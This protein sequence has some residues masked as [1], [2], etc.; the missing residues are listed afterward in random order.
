MLETLPLAELLRQYRAEARLSQEELA[1]RARVSPRTIGD[2]E[3]GVSLRPRAITISL[4]AQ[5]LELGSERREALHAASRRRKAA[6]VSGAALPQGV[7]LVGRDDEISRIRGLLLDSATRLVTLTGG[8]G[9]GKT[10]LA[11]AVA[12]HLAGEFGDR[13]F[14][15]EFAALPDAALVPTKIALALGVR[16]VR[17]ESV[18]ASL[19]AAI[20]ERPTLLVFDNFE[21]VAAAASMVA[22]LLAATSSL[23]VLVTS[24][25]P[26]HLSAER[27]VKVG[28]LSPDSSVRLLL[29]RVRANAPESE[30]SQDDPALE[31]LAQALGGLPLAIELAAPLLRT[32]SPAELIAR[33]E[34]PLDVLGA[35]RDSIAWSY[36]L[37]GA[38]EQR[39][40]RALA[41]FGGPFTESAAH[42]VGGNESG[43]TPFDTLRSI[44][45]LIDHSLVGV[46][47]DGAE[48]IEF[49]LHPLV[50]EFAKETLDR[51]G[52]NEAAHLRL[53]DY[54]TDVVRAAPRPE[55]LHDPATRARLNR[56][57]AHFDAVLGWLKMTGRIAL[58]LKLAFELWLI[59]Y[60]RG[61]NAHG[62]AWLCSLI[63]AAETSESTIDDGLL[64]DAHWAAGG[65][66]EASGQ[67]DEAER[68]AAFALP[69]KRTARDRP[70]VA[71]LLAGFGV[72][73]CARGEY[74]ATRAFL[75]E[76]LA[77]RRELGDGLDIA[78]ALTDL[79]SLAADEGKY[80]EANLCLEEALSRYRTAG[81]RM[82]ASLALG[83]LG[84]VALRSAAPAQAE[85]L[86]REA[87][88]VAEEVGYGESAR[89]A[90]MVLSR[91]LAD[92]GDLDA[93][94]TL[95]LGVAA[96]DDASPEQRAGIAR[97]L[98]SIEFRR[99]RTHLA[100]RLLGAAAAARSAFAIPLAERSDHERFLDSTARA[101]GAQFEREF[102]AGSAAG[103][104]T[105]LA[106]DQLR[107]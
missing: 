54:C 67:L 34:R 66:A 98:A 92:L 33:L 17:D 5:A 10:A 99:G 107:E 61:E 82:G 36:G 87:V 63:A 57:S 89:A 56:E 50:W 28:Q 96:E 64:A 45:T 25:V 40:L 16:Y 4:I 19:A 24:R 73:A 38:D 80:E 35:M 103:L 90:K 51:E 49:D 68:H 23:K 13:A 69:L 75:E 31:L 74:D 48:E 88:R 42:H 30:T 94:A 81:R 77:I 11:I 15:I 104:R 76:S 100:A 65:L 70:A 95:A 29:D 7:P 21:R 53:T 1:E 86:A 47:D 59:W 101:L 6:G 37:L 39:L 22:A 14:F 20:A 2:I 62:H 91:A 102:D 60:R 26:L 105:V 9:V 12:T 106:P 55:P 18:T 43:T 27:V 71:S 46:S 44:S 41:V 84:L 52:E 78:R 3:T 58:A 72:R 32:A 85:P 97:V 83:L 8:P 79:G 93:G